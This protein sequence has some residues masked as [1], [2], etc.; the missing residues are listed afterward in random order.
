M[1]VRNVDEIKEIKAHGEALYR[2]FFMR[3]DIYERL[4]MDDVLKVLGGFWQTT[5]GGGRKLDPH[6]HEDH[7]QVYYV[8]EGGGLLTVGAETKRVRKGDAVYIPPGTSH[9]FHNDT[10]ES[11]TIIMVDAPLGKR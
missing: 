1:I 9:S 4:G 8:L 3:K 6:S 11:C 7:E 10:D 2:Y 5:V